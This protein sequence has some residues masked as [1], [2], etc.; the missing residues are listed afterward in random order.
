MKVGD[1]ESIGIQIS[2]YS[3]EMFTAS[4]IIPVITKFGSA[5]AFDLEMEGIFLPEVKAIAY[6]FFRK[7]R[8]DFLRKKEALIIH[9]CEET[10]R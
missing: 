3:Y 1:Q 7:V 6:G 2:I 4:G 5:R 10:K 9:I 8:A